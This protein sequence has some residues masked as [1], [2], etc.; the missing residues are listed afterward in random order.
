M[1]RARRGRSE[2]SIFQ[3][4]DGSW[5]AEVSAGYDG[6]GRRRQRTLYGKIKGEVQEKPR[7]AQNDAGAGIVEAA[8][9]TVGEYLTRWLD[10]K[11][12]TIQPNTYVRYERHVRLHI[13]PHL[14]RVKLAKVDAFT[15]EQLYSLL[16]KGGMSATERKHIVRDDP[17]DRP[18]PRRPDQAHPAQSGRRRPQAPGPEAGDESPRAGRGPPVP[19][20]GPGRP[21]LCPV[22]P[23]P[24]QRHEAR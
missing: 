21:A 17:G 15:V 16:A 24:G 18:S 13:T 3:K 11:R 4:S 8:K 7:A 12:A 2:G 10:T 19:G 20:G 9:L 5:S 1:A 6:A 14:G 23:G 22:R